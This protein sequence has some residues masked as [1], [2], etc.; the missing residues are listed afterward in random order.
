MS[1][2]LDPGEVDKLIRLFPDEAHSLWPAAR[3]TARGEA[4]G[5]RL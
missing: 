3:G 2:R 1:H 4:P 5:W